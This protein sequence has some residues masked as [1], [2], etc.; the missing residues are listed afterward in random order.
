VNPVIRPHGGDD[1]Q[2]REVDEILRVQ[3]Q[4]EHV[5][6]ALGQIKQ[7]RLSAVPLQP[8]QGVEHRLRQ[9]HHPPAPAGI[10]AADRARVDL[11]LLFVQRH[12]GFLIRLSCLLVDRDD[13]GW[14]R[15]IHGVDVAGVLAGR[16]GRKNCST[17]GADV[18]AS[19]STDSHGVLDGCHYKIHE[20]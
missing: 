1:Q 9:P 13:E 15:L 17:R 16:H 18:P 11:D 3:H 2:R 8:G 7:H 14:W 10:P 12:H 20:K 4:T 6:A 19:A 5:E